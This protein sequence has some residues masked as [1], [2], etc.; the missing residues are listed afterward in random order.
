MLTNSRIVCSEDANWSFYNRWQARHKSPQSCG[1][2]LQIVT[3]L[4]FALLGLAS[5]SLHG[6]ATA[7]AEHCQ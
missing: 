6:M 2:G 5:V 1:K 7:D 4:I 3:H